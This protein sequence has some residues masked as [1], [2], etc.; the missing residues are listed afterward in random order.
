MAEQDEQLQTD[1]ALD[2]TLRRYLL[3]R[4]EANERLRLDERLLV[5]N[6]LA[7]RVALIES[8]LTDDYVAAR[9]GSAEREAFAQSFLITDSRR[10]NLRFTSELQRHSRLGTALSTVVTNPQTR[11]ARRRFA[12][13]FP[14][15][16]P[17]WATAG[18]LAV[19]L[20]LVGLV[21]FVAKQRRETQP[22]IAKQEAIPTPSL[23]AS[24][25]VAASPAISVPQPTPAKQTP[26]AT[27]AA[28]PAV[29]P[30]IASTVLLPGAIRDGGKLS[31]IALPKG[32]RDIVRLSLVLEEAADE[33]YQAELLTAEGQT[34]IAPAQ[35]KANLRNAEAR[36]VLDIP[37]RLLHNGD[38]QIN[39]SRRGSG[40]QFEPVGRYYFRALD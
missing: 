24:P 29:R 33:T 1:L 30:V 4:L 8:E 18:S 16:R 3:C 31:R 10:Q 38:Y 11:P 34:V 14:A 27:P 40:G 7:E 21:W 12:W 6:E 13:I 22:L 20:L 25:Q 26:A 32:D 23:L 17:V 5:D 37:A 28:E 35:L 39:L 19:L 9:L 15:N 36:V 2:E